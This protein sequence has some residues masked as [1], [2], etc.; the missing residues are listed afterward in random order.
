MTNEQHKK[1]HDLRRMIF[2]KW[3]NDPTNKE[4]TAQLE[5]LDKVL[6]N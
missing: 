5:L 6:F 2:A 4:L 3:V 1:L